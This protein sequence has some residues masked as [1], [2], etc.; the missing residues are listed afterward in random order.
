VNKVGIVN[1][2]HYYFTGYLNLYERLGSG[3]G[4]ES[5]IGS[6]IQELT[7]GVDG[8]TVGVS[9]KGYIKLWIKC[10]ALRIGLTKNVGDSDSQYVW[11][12]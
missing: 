2:I 7:T 1:S 11:I 4:W 8:A 9:L 12:V 10:C 6:D 3:E 5:K